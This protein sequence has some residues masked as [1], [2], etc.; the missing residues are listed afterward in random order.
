LTQIIVQFYLCQ[1]YFNKMHFFSSRKYFYLD[2]TAKLI[3]HY[4]LLDFMEKKLPSSF[5]IIFLAGNF[6]AQQKTIRKVSDATNRASSPLVYSP[7][8]KNSGWQPKQ[9]SMETLLS[10]FLI[11]AVHLGYYFYRIRTAGYNNYQP[12]QIVSL[13]PPIRNIGMK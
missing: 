1:Y 6:A 10:Q 8:P 11:L 12:N 3:Q 7:F 5:V 4:Q 9:T 2:W 13:K